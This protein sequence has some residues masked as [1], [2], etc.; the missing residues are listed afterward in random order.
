MAEGEIPHN[1]DVTVFQQKTI[2]SEGETESL[3]EQRKNKQEK[4]LQSD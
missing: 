3:E 4:G 2:S 1:C